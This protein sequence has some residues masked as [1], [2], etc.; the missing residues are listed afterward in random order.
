MYNVSK[1]KIF[2]IKLIFFVT[3]FPKQI[4]FFCKCAKLFP[5]RHIIFPSIAY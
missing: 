5:Y 3:N 2:N 1:K 4:K